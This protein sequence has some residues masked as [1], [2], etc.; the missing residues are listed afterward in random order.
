MDQKNEETLRYCMM[1]G[2][3][4]LCLNWKNFQ[5]NISTAFRSLRS[6]NELADVTLACEDGQIFS[7][8][9]VILASSSPFFMGILKKYKNPQPLIFLK[10]M[11]SEDLSAIL[12]FFYFGEANIDQES[13]DAFLGLADDL[14]VLGL[15]RTEDSVGVGKA[16][17]IQNKK[18]NE[19]HA[20]VKIE[21]G[22]NYEKREN[23]EYVVDSEL[24]TANSGQI[25]NTK[26]AL[27]D[28]E[29]IRTK[30]MSMMEYSENK[31]MSSKK[32]GSTL[33]RARICKVCRKEGPFSTVWNH[34]E[35]KHLDVSYPCNQCEKVSKS[36]NG[37]AQHR[38]SFH[39]K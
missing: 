18:G 9:K 15:T 20:E 39:S 21:E 14:K 5:T 17:E 31:V 34:I 16:E 33:G 35:A 22:G 13:L 7:A 8:H 24:A 26:A 6:E 25:E 32:P 30:V 19:P 36:R 28:G 4:K 27:V 38:V 23:H 37:L 29:D 12:D 2:P 1:A 11:R 3:Q 10:G